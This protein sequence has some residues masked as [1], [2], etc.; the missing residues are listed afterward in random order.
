MP[1]VETWF[2]E[3]T[4]VHISGYNTYRRHRASH[5]RDACIYV[6][7][8]LDSCEISHVVLTD[9]AVEQVWCTIKI[10]NERIL[11]GCIYIP[12]PN[13]E[14][15]AMF[16]SLTMVDRLMNKCTYTGLMLTGDL[17]KAQQA[18]IISDSR[19]LL[20]NP[21]LVLQ[22]FSGARTCSSML[23]FQPSNACVWG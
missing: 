6:H 8:D 13:A 9:S 4:S 22:I 15:I 16:I 1:I 23:A 5:A 21:K 20:K 7:C 11:I 17:T 12:D 19:Q 14:N 3:S 18:G 10:C 2:T